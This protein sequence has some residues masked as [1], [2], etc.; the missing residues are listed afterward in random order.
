MYGWDTLVLLQHLL[1]AQL[2]KTAI[3][4]RL[5]VSRRVI[6]HWIATGQ[7]ARDLDAPPPRRAAPRATKLDPYK[8]TIDERLGPRRC[9]RPNGSHPIQCAILPGESVQFYSGVDTRQRF[10]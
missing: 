5:G 6:Y 10:A 3:A 8:P 4:Q 7:L 1:E 9:Q 2:S